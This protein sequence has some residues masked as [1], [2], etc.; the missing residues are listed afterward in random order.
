MTHRVYVNPSGDSRFRQV[1]QALAGD[2]PG[3]PE[4]LQAAL[5]EEWPKSRVVRGI[6]DSDHERWYAYR[7]GSWVST[8]P[9]AKGPSDEEL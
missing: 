7:D 5:R 8:Q 9:P 6:V 1:A 3:T 4:E 2:G